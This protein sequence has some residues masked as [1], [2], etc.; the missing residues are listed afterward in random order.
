MAIPKQSSPPKHTDSLAPKRAN[1]I[2]FFDLAYERIEERLINCE[3]KPGMQLTLSELQDATG[4]GRTPVH[5][6][7]SQLAADTLFIVLPRHGL[8]VAPIDLGRERRLLPLRRDMERFVVR[9]AIDHA[10]PS[11]RNQF[12]HM[13][14]TLLERRD[15]MSL[16]EFNVLDRRINQLLLSASGEPFLEHTLRPLHTIYRRIGF[17]HHNL[18]PE[19]SNL[20]TTIDCHLTVLN[21]AANRNLAK[22][23]SATDALIDFV[24]SMFIEMELGIDPQL[25]DC[26]IEPVFKT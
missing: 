3:L 25:L 20:S 14:R 19:K 23:L 26:G 6:A 5:S 1:R 16:A 8:K 13:E 22:A 12:L 17:I 24:D 4:L 10:S 9:M 7:V 15:S 18:T 11:H 21:A 2:N